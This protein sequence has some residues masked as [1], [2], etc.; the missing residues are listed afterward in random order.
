MITA[1]FL[2]R[3][4]RRPSRPSSHLRRDVAFCGQSIRYGSC[5]F[6]SFACPR[7]RAAANGVFIL[8]PGSNH[9]GRSRGACV[10][11]RSA[12]RPARSDVVFHESAPDQHRHQWPARQSAQGFQLTPMISARP[13]EGRDPR[14]ASSECLAEVPI[15][16]WRCCTATPA[17]RR[18]AIWLATRSLVLAVSPSP[19]AGRREHRGHRRSPLDTAP[20]RHCPDVLGILWQPLLWLFW[21]WMDAFAASSPCGGC[22]KEQALRAGR[23]G[24]ELLTLGASKFLLRTHDDRP[25]LHR[26]DAA[27]K[28][29]SK[30]GRK[31]KPPPGSPSNRTVRRLKLSC[32]PP[33]WSSTPRSPSPSVVDQ[34][35]QTAHYVHRVR[36]QFVEP[37]ISLAIPL[38]MAVWLV[39]IR[40]AQALLFAP[41][42]FLPSGR[43]TWRIALTRLLPFLYLLGLALLI[44]A[45]HPN[46]FRIAPAPTPSPSRCSWMSPIH[47]GPRLSTPDTPKTRLDVVKDF[48]RFILQRR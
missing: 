7:S 15:A 17:R 32:R 31:W 1:P 28:R 46:D 37:L 30:P 20:G 8:C 16:I 25:P 45:W 10:F 26:T 23:T 44:P 24:G 11:L 48:T 12:G 42:A 41:V 34:A 40:I 14:A 22:P 33:T 19:S 2:L 27:V 35:S 43:S 4:P 9:E 13:L 21:K 38:L 47:A 3:L 36:R 39:F 5:C 18:P 29:R 6:S